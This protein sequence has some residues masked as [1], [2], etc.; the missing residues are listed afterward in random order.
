MAGDRGPG[1]TLARPVVILAGIAAVLFLLEALRPAVGSDMRYVEASWEMQSSHD[2]LIPHLAFVPYFEKPILLYWLGAACQWLFG[3]SGPATQ[4]PSVLCSVG[5]L[6]VTYAWGVSLRGPRFGLAGAGLLLGSGLFFAM[7]SI[8]TT[9]P[10]LALCV[11]TAF[12]CAWRHEQGAGGR[13]IWC[14]WVSAALGA[15]AKGPLAWVLIGCGIAPYLALSRPLVQ[16]PRAVWAMRPVSGLA[17]LL[18]V[19]VPWWWAVWRVD[20]RFVEFFF[21]R[22]NLQGL[23]NANINHPGPPWYYVGI[24]AMAL[25]P[26]TLLAA[27]P[28]LARMGAI[29]RETWQDLRSRWRQDGAAPAAP[30]AGQRGDLYLLC[31]ALMPFLFLSA[32]AS[33]LQTYLLPLMPSFILLTAQG[34]APLVPAAPR[35]MARV[36]L[37]EIILVV[38]ALA[39][40]IVAVVHL[41]LGAVLTT[42][43][44]LLVAL[45]G[46]AV[47]GSLGLA[48][49]ALGRGDLVRALVA[50]GLGTALAVLAVGP[51]ILEV[52]LRSNATL[53]ARY[54]RGALHDGDELVICTALAQNYEIVNTLHRR[55]AYAGPVRELGMGHFTEATTHDQALPERPDEVGGAMLAH[56]PWLLSEEHLAAQWSAARRIWLFADDGI[57]E[58][59]RGA[60]CQVVL[61]AQTRKALLVSNQSGPD[62]GPG[63]R[64]APAAAQATSTAEPRR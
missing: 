47:L 22:I 35:W 58:R 36:V 40:L 13:W 18:A 17:V 42:R 53:L 57:V 15:L 11:T 38:L 14:F 10:L 6:L 41:G 55:C 25:A 7:G 21:I 49:R 34:L 28:L 1:S 37:G 59:L 56:D 16:L 19:N 20:P 48:Y 5:S 43:A 31:T 26:F 3:E 4:L 24:L 45:A 46:V 44:H 9:D 12:Y 50:L 62:P 61:L 51:V 27:V 30:A 33:K 60:H 63:L 52:R 29:G 8:L 39:G 23:T 64:P 32:S 2:W 54:V